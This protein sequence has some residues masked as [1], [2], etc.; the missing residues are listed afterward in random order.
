MLLINPCVFSGWFVRFFES[1]YEPEIEKVRAIR[2]STRNCRLWYSLR[3]KLPRT[4]DW[5]LMIPGLKGT[6]CSTFCSVGGCPVIGELMKGAA[7]K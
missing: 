6:R 2:R 4:R 7:L 1:A 3:K 5:A